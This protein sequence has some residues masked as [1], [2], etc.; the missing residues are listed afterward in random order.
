MNPANYR[1]ALVEAHEDEAEG[2]D[3]LLVKPGLPYLDIIRLLKNHSPLPIAAYQVSSEYSMIKAGGV[4]KMIDEE[5]VMM[6]TLMC[7]CRPGA[8]IILTYFALKAANSLCGEKN[9]V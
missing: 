3:I 6:E 7:L 4:L 5:R 9:L 8:D 1:E 2:A